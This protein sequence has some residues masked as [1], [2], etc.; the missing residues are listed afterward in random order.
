[1]RK[2]DDLTTGFHFWK[3]RHSFEGA[4]EH[5]EIGKPVEGLLL[6][7]EACLFELAAVLYAFETRATLLV[8]SVMRKELCTKTQ[9]ML[10][11]AR[12]QIEA[13]EEDQ[14]A[15]YRY[16][17][18]ERI[19]AD[20]EK[21]D[22]E[23]EQAVMTPIDEFVQ[24]LREEVVEQLEVWTKLEHLPEDVTHEEWSEGS[25]VMD[26]DGVDD[27]Q[28]EVEDRAWDALDDTS[29]D[30]LRQRPGQWEFDDAMNDFRASCLIR[31]S[32]RIRLAVAEVSVCPEKEQGCAREG[33]SHTF[34][35]AAET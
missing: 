31:R 22:T 10:R 34:T 2:Y 19:E 7:K 6:L 12:G 24:G 29:D 27:H 23:I 35:H 15:A 4:T 17:A 14:G 28:K 9:S 25:E 5:L 1:M 18:L 16:R 11:M 8:K 20:L 33:Y 13:T 3:H 30:F 32:R 21:E 26:I